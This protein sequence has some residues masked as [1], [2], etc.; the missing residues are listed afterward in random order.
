MNEDGCEIAGI[1]MPDVSVP[2]ASHTGFNPR[3]RDTGASGQLLEYVGSTFPFKMNRAEREA[4]NDPRPSLEERYTS[5]DEYLRLV[6]AAAEALVL[7]R[8]LLHQ[9]VTLCVD[10]AADRYDVCMVSKAAVWK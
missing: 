7:Q 9:D 5:R 2:V 8:Y 6:E 10:I 4:T 3:H 1:S